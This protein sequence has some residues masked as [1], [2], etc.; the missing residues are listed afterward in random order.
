[1][2]TNNHYYPKPYSNNLFNY[3]LIINVIIY[4]IIKHAVLDEIFFL[5]A[6]KYI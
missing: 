4:K 6:V 2:N 3:N 1:M 5:N